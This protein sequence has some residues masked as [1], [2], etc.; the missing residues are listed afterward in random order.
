MAKHIK[1]ILVYQAQG[2]W[3]RFYGWHAFNK[4]QQ[5]LYFPCCK[6]VHGLALK[7][8]LWVL[9]VDKQGRAI[10]SWRSLKPNRFLYCWRAYGVL[11]GA[12]ITKAQRRKLRAALQKTGLTQLIPW[13]LNYFAQKY[14]DK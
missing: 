11:E 6:A 12:V 2:F 1:P 10:G 14:C 5:L 8:P 7:Y 4:P 9:F 3:A 13:R